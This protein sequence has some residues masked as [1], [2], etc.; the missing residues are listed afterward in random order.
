MPD[1]S[2][3]GQLTRYL[4]TWASGDCDDAIIDPCVDSTCTGLLTP[5][6]TSEEGQLWSEDACI[7]DQALN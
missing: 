3:R 2:T 7:C 1:N 5:S 4:G 6:S